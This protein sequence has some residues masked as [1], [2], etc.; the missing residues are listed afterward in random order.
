MGYS[1][2]V[3]SDPQ[4]D[5]V[6]LANHLAITALTRGGDH[7]EFL[8]ESVPGWQELSEEELAAEL[9]EDATEADYPQVFEDTTTDHE[10]SQDHDHQR[11]GADSIPFETDMPDEDEET[12]D[13]LEEA[14]ELTQQ[15]HQNAGGEEGNDETD[16]PETE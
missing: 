8:E 1:C 10:H 15:R 12:A 4:A 11:S 5:G 6:H 9:I 2:P 13:V 3:C 7:E 14:M 16:E